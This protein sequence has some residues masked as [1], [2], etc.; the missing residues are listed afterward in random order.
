MYALGMNIEEAYE[1]VGKYVPDLSAR[2]VAQE[3]WIVRHPDYK[4]FAY[5]DDSENYEQNG[6]LSFDSTFD[7]FDPM[8]STSDMLTAK[9]FLAVM[10]LALHAYEGISDG[11]KKETN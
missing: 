11:Q 2:F 9:M 4:T 6:I 5:L 1:I 10:T 3:K 8:P 7:P